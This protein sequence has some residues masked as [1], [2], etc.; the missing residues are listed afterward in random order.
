M[1]ISCK[2]LSVDDH[3]LG[4]YEEGAER[5]RLMTSARLEGIRTLDV[6]GRHLPRA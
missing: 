1:S 2:R 6:L 5:K 4:H 3:A